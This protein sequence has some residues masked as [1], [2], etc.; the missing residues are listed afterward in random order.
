MVYFEG[1]APKMYTNKLKDIWNGVH[2]FD[3]IAGCGFA[4]LSKNAPLQVFSIIFAQ[5]CSFL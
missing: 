4:T 2:F 1:G 5:I 3:K